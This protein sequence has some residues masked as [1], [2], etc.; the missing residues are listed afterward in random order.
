MCVV[1]CFLLIQNSSYEYLFD[2]GIEHTFFKPQLLGLVWFHFQPSFFAMRFFS[3]CFVLF[4]NFFSVYNF[5]SLF[6]FKLNACVC[7]CLFVVFFVLWWSTI[8][9]NTLENAVF[10]I[11]T[12]TLHL[13]TEKFFL[14][15]TFAQ[16]FRWFFSFF[17]NFNSCS[18]KIKIP[19]KWNNLKSFFSYVAAVTDCCWICVCFTFWQ[20]VFVFF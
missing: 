1:V 8:V 6:M 17:K 19:L 3:I 5:L 4:F 15:K 16:N 2:R 9:W 14:E 7:V 12:V 13:H 10:F 11:P 20:T 18:F